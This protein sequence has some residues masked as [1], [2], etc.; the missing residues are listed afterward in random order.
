MLETIQ[1]ILEVDKLLFFQ[2][3]NA[4]QTEKI[5]LREEAEMA[6]IRESV[7][8]DLENKKIQC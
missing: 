5:S 6:E 3:E 4:D 1:I 7:K 8:L 2:F